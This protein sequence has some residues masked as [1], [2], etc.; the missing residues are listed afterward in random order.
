MG[1][2]FGLAWTRGAIAGQDHK[3]LPLLLVEFIYDYLS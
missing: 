1:D 3:A 2:V